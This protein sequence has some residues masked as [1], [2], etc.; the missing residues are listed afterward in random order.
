MLDRAT[1]QIISHQP[2]TAE[3]QVWSWVS[4]CGICH[5][6]RG[7]GTVFLSWVLQFS[8]VRTIPSMLHTHLFIYYRCHI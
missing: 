7:T 2:L 1:A 6:Q 8:F 5:G 3:D 4:P